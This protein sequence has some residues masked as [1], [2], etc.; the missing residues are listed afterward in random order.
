MAAPMSSNGRGVMVAP[1]DPA[2]PPNGAGP[3]HITKRWGDRPG[4]IV[5]APSITKRATLE[6]ILDLRSISGMPIIGVI[7]YRRTRRLERSHG[8]SGGSRNSSDGA[9]PRSDRSH[10]ADVEEQV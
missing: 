6:P 8:N 5:V 9:S 3:G 7:N 4:L 2:V 10:P 1:F